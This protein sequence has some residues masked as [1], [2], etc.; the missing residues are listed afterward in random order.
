[1]KTFVH[2]LLVATCLVAY[3]RGLPGGR[4]DSLEDDSLEDAV[5]VRFS[6]PSLNIPNSFFDTFNSMRQ[7][8]LNYFWNMSDLTDIKIPEGANTTSTTK[9]IDGH[10]VTINE[11]TYTSGD[12]NG[13]T[14]FRIRTIDVMP[15]NNTLLLVDSDADTTPKTGVSESAETLENEISRNGDV[16]TA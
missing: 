9:I 15:Q 3:A 5:N 16:L 1:M 12:E 7:N 8:I 6:L 2:I 4:R 10:V 11:T 13:G 14:V